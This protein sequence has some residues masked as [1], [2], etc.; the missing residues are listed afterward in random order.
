MIHNEDA[1]HTLAS[2][3]RKLKREA[4]TIP[5]YFS[6]VSGEAAEGLRWARSKSM[7]QALLGWGDETRRF[8]P[9]QL[10]TNPQ[11]ISLFIVMPV[12]DLDLYEPWIQC[13][14]YRN[15]CSHA[16][17]QGEAKISSPDLP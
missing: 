7:E 14:F 9:R 1:H 2:E 13:L 11:G 6:Y 15:F 8:D 17:K 16:A 10:K 12:D 3:A 5:K 4:K